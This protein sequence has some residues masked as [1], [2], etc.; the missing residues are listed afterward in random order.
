MRQK[1]RI[2]IVDDNPNERERLEDLLEPAGYQ[3]AFACNGPQ[4]LAKTVEFNP[5][6]ILLDEKLP[7]TNGLEVCSQL[8]AASTA[9]QMPIILVTGPNDRRSRLKG[10]EAGADAFIAKPFDSVELSA[11]VQSAVRLNRYR[12]LM[13]ERSRFERMVEHAQTGYLLLNDRDQILFAN[14]AAARHLN[15]A[16]L[17]GHSSDVRFLRVA[18]EQ[19]RCEPAETWRAWPENT[20]NNNQR[21]LVRPETPTSQ[22]MW[23]QVD[24][25]DSLDSAAEP[26]WIVSLEDVTDRMSAYQERRN[27]HKVVTHKLRTPFIS[28]LTGLEL[29]IKHLDQL[30]QEEIMELS[31]DAYKWAKRLYEEV[32]TVIRY[33]DP[34]M[35]AEQKAGFNLGLLP[36]LVAGVSAEMG[37]NNVSISGAEELMGVRVSLA[38]P[39]LEAIF[40]EVFDNAEKFHPQNRPEIQISVAYENFEEV[41][42]HISDDGLTLS[43]QQLEQ[44]WTPYYQGEKYFTGMV[45]GMGLGLPLLASLVWSV[46]GRCRLYNRVGRPGVTVDLTLPCQVQENTERAHR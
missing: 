38:R 40:R 22:A 1:S 2:L 24:V 32:E 9:A 28:I 29:L 11:T 5:D 27:F 13:A 35:L 15:L 8:R 14:P 33:A 30:S 18:K 31:N 44:A 25:L 12:R 21:F 42:L 39:A 20:A 23:L 37:L 41:T 6:L 45:E 17:N 7:D 46:G 26:S 3:L 10:I 36:G 43:P 34:S 16:A 19:Y 4:A